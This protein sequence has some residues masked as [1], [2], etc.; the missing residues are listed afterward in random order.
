MLYAKLTPKLYNLHIRSFTHH[1]LTTQTR[2]FVFDICI[3][4]GIDDNF[5]SENW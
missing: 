2:E 5:K 1:K 4:G 3:G